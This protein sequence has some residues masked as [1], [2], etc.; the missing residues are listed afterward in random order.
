MIKPTF[1]KK[2][3]ILAWLILTMAAATVVATVLY[4]SVYLSNAIFLKQYTFKR[5]YYAAVAGVEYAKFIIKNPATY[6]PTNSSPATGPLVAW[7]KVMPFDPFGDGSSLVNNVT[8]DNTT[9]PPDYT[10]K[11]T[12]IAAGQSK[13]ITATSTTTGFIKK[14]Q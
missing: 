14:W 5:A 9:S 13:T 12:G 11:S 8:I 2:G 3:Y 4:T 10:I 6:D 1:K 7:P